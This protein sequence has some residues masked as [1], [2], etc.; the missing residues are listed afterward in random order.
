[1]ET[2]QSP[3]ERADRFAAALVMLGH[4]PRRLAEPEEDLL[5]Q[6]ATLVAAAAL[7][8]V[9][10]AA[11]PAV[12]GQPPVFAEAVQTVHG[13]PGDPHHPVH[14]HLITHLGFAAQYVHAL[15]GQ[16]PGQRRPETLRV[17]LA[18]SL[19]MLGGAAGVHDRVRSAHMGVVRGTDEERVEAVSY[20]FDA[21]ELTR[22]ARHVAQTAQ[23][24]VAHLDQVAPEAGPH[25]AAEGA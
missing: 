21:A 9:E 16:V 15:F 5:R 4:T 20:V 12:S 22:L 25:E 14:D 23:E 17:L 11:D 8:Y 13:Y 1:M 18:F 19:A 2:S 7:P 3:R 6:Q 10:S 24:F